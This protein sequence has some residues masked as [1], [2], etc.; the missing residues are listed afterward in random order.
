MTDCMAEDCRDTESGGESVD[1]KRV[2]KKVW[3]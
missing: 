3:E 1:E 2:R